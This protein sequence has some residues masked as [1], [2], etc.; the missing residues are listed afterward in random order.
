MTPVKPTAKSRGQ[1]AYFKVHLAASL[2]RLWFK[3]GTFKDTCTVAKP[4]EAWKEDRRLKVS[5]LAMQRGSETRRVGAATPQ[6]CQAS[7]GSLVILEQAPPYSH[8][9]LCI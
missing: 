7:L 9:P 5:W 2:L 6:S 3:C 4:N 1:A 8:L